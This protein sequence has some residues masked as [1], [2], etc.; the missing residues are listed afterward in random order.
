MFLLKHKKDGS[1]DRYK[2]CLVAKGYSQCP[3][4]DFKDTFA[5]TAK[6][7][8]LHAILALAALEDLELESIDISSAF[9][10]GDL[11]EE[12][13]MDQ[14]EGFHQ[15]A[16]D[17]FLQL[18]KGLYGLRQS[19]RIWHKK[20]DKVLQ[21]IGFTKVR[22]DHSIWIYQKDNVKII[23]PVFV[24]DM[25]LASKSKEAIQHVKAELKARFKLRDLGPTTFLLGVGV[26]RD[27]TKR[28]LHLSQCQYIKDLLEQYN[29]ADCSPVGT[30]M[31]PGTKLTTEQAPSTP[32][33]I[34]QM[35]TV[36]YIHAVGSLMYLAVATRPDIAYA[37]GVLARFNSNPGKAH[38]NAVKHLFRYLKGTLDY[39]LTYG[40]S[41]SSTTSEMFQTYS[42][43]DHGGDKDSGQS[44]GAY[45]VKL[46]T[47]AISWS[48]KL[49][50]IVTLSTTE[51]E[52]IAAVAA[53]QEILWLR[54][55][56]SELGYKT[57]DAS[58][59][60]IDNQSAVSV[61]KNPEHHGR[62]KHLDL[63]FYWLRDI[64]D[65]GQI[66]VVHCPTAKMP[67]DLLTKSLTRVKVGLCR[68]MLGLA[69]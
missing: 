33:E 42:D 7:S 2:G 23:I 36:P 34:E 64:V 29:H 52:Y 5:P 17:D 12:V 20:L 32:E 62:I 60:Y 16:Y 66:S 19:P 59:L 35:K 14:P 39:K 68:D 51:A 47:G 44:T 10:N 58:T 15:G 3:G 27:R 30:P 45:V 25:T 9:L 21:E 56:F 13:Y 28:V 65:S 18:L 11:E 48:S 24:D 6:W 53:G 67:A 43:A 61:A 4:F 46:G 49:Q 54:N 41:S 22:C 1:I 40:P 69:L 8:A 38:W 37:V 50:T 26:E 57:K 31:D 63:R 55:L